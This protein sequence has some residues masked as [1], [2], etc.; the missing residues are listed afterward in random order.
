MTLIECGSHFRILCAFII[1]CVI[2]S[3]YALSD[4]LVIVPVVHLNTSM[5]ASPTAPMTEPG[6]ADREKP[7]GTCLGDEKI[8]RSFTDILFMI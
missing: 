6:S 2:G 5:L 7:Q 8:G 4:Y 1:A 3:A